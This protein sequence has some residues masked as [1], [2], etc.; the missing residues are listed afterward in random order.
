MST[1]Q[2]KFNILSIWT[3]QILSLIVFSLSN[4]I[5]WNLWGLIIVLSLNLFMAQD[6]G[7]GK[8]WQGAII[9]KIMSKHITQGNK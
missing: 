4:R 6:Y 5:A 3:P 9:G 2:L 1:C 8:T 7:L